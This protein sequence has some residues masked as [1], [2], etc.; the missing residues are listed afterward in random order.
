MREVRRRKH[1]P[2]WRRA[3]RTEEEG[4]ET[5]GKTTQE[6]KKPAGPAEAVEAY[7]AEAEKKLKEMA[8]RM[9]ADQLKARTSVS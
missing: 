7:R 2:P 5:N 8:G 4:M 1:K 9:A 3:V 6:G